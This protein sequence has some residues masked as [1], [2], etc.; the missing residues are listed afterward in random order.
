M[1]ETFDQFFDLTVRPIF[2]EKFD[3]LFNQQFEI[4]LSLHGN[5]QEADFIKNIWQKFGTNQNYN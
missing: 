3:Q 5:H 2:D 4:L 1:D